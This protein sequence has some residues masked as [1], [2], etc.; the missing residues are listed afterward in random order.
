VPTVHASGGKVHLGPTTR[1]SNHDLRW[2]LVEAACS[3]VA[4]QQR[5]GPTHTVLQYRR[6]KQFKCHGKAA[7]AVA[8][9]RHLAESTWWILRHKQPYREPVPLAVSSSMHGQARRSF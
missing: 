3:I 6:L 2:A 4:L 7:V 8:V 1:Q 9:A 5:H